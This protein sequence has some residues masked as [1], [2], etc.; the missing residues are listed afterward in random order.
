LLRE[1]L[2]TTAL[3]ALVLGLGSASGRA[4]DGSEQASGS[5]PKADR[6][7]LS[8][9]VNKS[10]VL[11]NR[12]GVRRILIGNPDI[13]EALAVSG[14]EVVVNGKAPGETTLVLWETNGQRSLFDVHVLPGHLKVDTVREEL[15]RELQGQQVSLR[16]EGNSVFLSGTVND[17]SAADRAVSIASTLGKVVDLLSVKVP[18]AE[19]QILLKVRFVN[20]D[21][22]ASIELGANLISTGATNTIG[23]ISTQQFTPP[24]ADKVAQGYNTQFSFSDALNILL[25]RPDL[26][27]GATIRA[28]QA[29]QL[30]EI[31][32]EPNV[33]T[34]SGKSASFLAGGEFPFP[35]LQGGGAGIGQ[36]T[37]QFR[38]F[39]VRIHFLPTVTARGT[40]RLVVTPEVSSLDFAN[41]LT[42]QGFT[43]PGLATR[44][45]QTEVELASGQS[46][47]IAGLL[48]N[49]LT[50]TL[51]KVPGLGDIPLLGKIFQSKLESRSRSE[52]LVLVTPEV[53]DPVPAGAAV[54]DIPM[55]KGFMKGLPMTVPSNPVTHGSADGSKW[56]KDTL[57]SETLR[58]MQPVVPSTS[59]AAPVLPAP[60][61]ADLPAAVSSQAGPDLPK[62]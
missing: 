3:F 9:L 43:V 38:E 30:A 4:A 23:G 48:D 54:P 34:V 28:L 7:D 57:P 13:A 1:P 53:V 61:G 24:T 25:F 26:N 44:R 31:L 36:V 20:V 52:L 8:V 58:R 27:L 47:A 60:V 40:I 56:R 6:S 35:T 16:L 45:V 42:V 33:L 11:E 51:N 21:R 19:P 2:I 10:V 50:E 15:A 49:R 29:K 62:N 5:L 18:P 46:F 12:N 37:I 39:G 32:A 41:G 55:P 59:G 14:T 22:E 17:L